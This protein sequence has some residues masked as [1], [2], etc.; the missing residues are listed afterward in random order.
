MPIFYPPHDVKRLPQYFRE[1][2][3]PLL[4]RRLKFFIIRSIILFLGYLVKLLSSLP[5]K[6]FRSE[7]FRG[8]DT[9]LDILFFEV[10]IILRVTPRAAPSE[11]M[12]KEEA[13]ADVAML[14]LVSKFFGA[15]S[16]G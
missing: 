7:V 12:L 1:S 2:K 13:V 14:N 5:L 11:A 16:V 8:E 3:N 10:L 15:I 6:R 4:Y 9:I